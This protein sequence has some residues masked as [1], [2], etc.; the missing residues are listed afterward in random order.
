[1]LAELA[2]VADGFGTPFV[3]RS[4]AG[5]GWVDS[6]SMNEVMKEYIAGGWHKRSPRG[7]RVFAARHAGFLN[8]VDIFTPEEMDR[9]AIFTEFLRPRGFGWEAATGIEAPSGDSLPFDIERRFEV[10]PGQPRHDRAARR[11]AAAFG[12]RRVALGPF[13][14]G[15]RPRCHRSAGAH[16]S[17]GD[18]AWIAGTPACDGV[19]TPLRALW[20]DCIEQ[21]PRVQ[22]NVCFGPKVDIPR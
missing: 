20:P 13:R 15:A 17:S 19:P 1:M 16:R 11:A 22:Q 8:D 14:A 3:A 7:P 2:K 21:P 9:E 5:Y 18:N 6:P 12:V 10:G 4:G